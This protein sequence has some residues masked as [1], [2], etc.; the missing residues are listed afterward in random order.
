MNK[1]YDEIVKSIISEWRKTAPEE[2]PFQTKALERHVIPIIYHRIRKEIL[3][4]ESNR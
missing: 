1:D 4:G 2:F 3:Q